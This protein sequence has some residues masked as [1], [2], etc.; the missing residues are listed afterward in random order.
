MIIDERDM[1]TLT[2]AFCASSSVT[3]SMFY[4]QQQQQQH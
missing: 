3:A 2:K 4:Q 1:P